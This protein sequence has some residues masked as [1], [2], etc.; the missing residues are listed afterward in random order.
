MLNVQRTLDFD[1][2]RATE[3]ERVQAI[4]AR[5]PP[6]LVCPDRQ[7]T[8]G[9]A[10]HWEWPKP[11]EDQD[12]ITVDRIRED[13]DGP[14]HRFVIERGSRVEVFLGNGRFE[15]GTVTGISH[16]NQEVRVAH[17][18]NSDGLWYA[19]E[20]IYPAAE[21]TRPEHPNSAP[22]SKIITAASR[23]PPNGFSEEDRV[24][25]LPATCPY[26]FD[27][28]K[29]FRRGFAEGSLTYSDYQAQFARLSESK[30][31]IV[32]ELKFRF[33]AT[34]LAVVASRMGSV[35]AK[36]STKDE[37]AA[38]IYRK[39]LASFVL[40]G[41]VSYSM[42][43]RYEDAVAKK[44]H[45]VTLVDYVAAFAN[46]QAKVE[47]HKKALSDPRTF[48]EFRTFL[49]EKCEDDLSDEQ[50]AR[51]DALHVDMTREQRA[52]QKSVTVERFQSE[53]ISGHEF[54]IKQGF[55][56][57]RQRPLWIVTLTSRVERTTFD[58]LNRK[59]RM[60]GGW[61]SSFKKSD[62]GFQFIEENKA[63]RF[64]GLLTGNVDRRDVLSA[65]K[66]RKELTAAERL[67]ELAS[68]LALR[69][70]ETLEASDKSL[71]NTARRADI[72]A[73]VRGRAFAE[74]A[75]A[76]TMHSIAEALSCGKAKY[77]D[78]IR[79]K[80][81][82]ETLETILYLAKWAR[83]RAARQRD[84][85]S[86]YAHGRRVDRI[87]SQP[88]GVLDIR[89]AE[90]PYP[91]VYM[92][93]LEQAVLRCRSTKGV[94]QA[95]EKMA[96]RLAREKDDFVTFRQEHD[97]ELLADFLDRAKGTTANVEWIETALEKY[98]RLQRA[99][100]T[101]IHELRSALREFMCH[102]AETRGDDP[103][104][105]AERELIGKKLPGFFPTPRPII[106]MLLE[107]AEIA[108]Q[109]R[110]LE[111]SCGKGDILDAIQADHSSSQ[112]H[113]IEF[114]RTLSDVLSAKGH[115]VEF[116]DFL[117]HCTDYDRIVMNPPFENGQDIDHIRHAFKLLAPGGRLVSVTSEGPFCR[118]DNKSV[119]FRDW[120]ED[121][122]AKVERLPE[123]S[124][125]GTEAFRATSI[126]T[127]LV[128]ITKEANA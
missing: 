80:A 33:K 69:A 17:R 104:K 99:N 39:M 120:L 27:E 66:E 54:V 112:I 94:K 97:I 125:M 36:R 42:A 15:L 68:A 13:I 105:V 67:H 89:F 62:A 74:A 91:S 59:A 87:D 5:P 123:D 86:S 11:N 64:A 29:A 10:P 16:R 79:Q 34:E 118:V 119:A 23:E 95:S 32:S 84:K 116:S 26:T 12:R 83:V 28:Y 3:V 110:I 126:R 100:I 101:D 90:Y 107:R 113:A 31:A 71:Q 115:D 73:G 20:C 21:D 82:V 72:Q 75:L 127:R 43:E 76:R 63:Q 109:H 124:F 4:T 9:G 128:T 7:L 38:S 50:L 2:P 114:N 24:S 14:S 35:H 103:V 77:L 85:E 47:E 102:R 70:E 18:D 22:L 52:A 61:F 106:E 111:P 81:Q 92:R 78:G 88:I 46:R 58:E 96:K 19:K 57:K 49:Q 8:Y 45:T 60:L 122:G 53:E 51:Y 1:A 117:E 121:V 6:E 30:D 56:D 98:G 25:S 93:H 108:D 65:R 55:H 41:T 48:F 37:N 40:D 44:V